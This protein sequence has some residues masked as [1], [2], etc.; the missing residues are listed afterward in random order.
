MSTAPVTEIDPGPDWF[1]PESAPPRPRWWG[2][3]AVF[4]AV[5]LAGVLILAGIGAANGKSLIP[6]LHAWDGNWYLRIAAT[7]YSALSVGLDA[8]GNAAVDT[9][10]AFFPGYPVAI[11]LLGALTHL[12]PIAAGLLIS[13]VAG[14]TA[15]YGI[16]RLCHLLNYPQWTGMIGVALFAATPM[17]VTLSM[18]YTE[19]LFTALAIWALVGI[20]RQNWLA[21]A[22][23]CGFAGLV[24][25]S[26]AVLVAV[27]G[28]ALVV[29]V[30]RGRSHPAALLYLVAGASGLAGYYAF[31]VN[32]TDNL[33]GWFV[34]QKAGWGTAF[35]FGK[36]S[37]TFAW[38]VLTSDAPLMETLNVVSMLGAVALAVIAVRERLPWPLAAH[39]IGIVVMTIGS[40][41]VTY[42]KMRLLVPAATLLIPVAA[43]LARRRPGT[44]IAVLA[45]VAV[46][47]GWIGAYALTDWRYAI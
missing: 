29:S 1:E 33:A 36:D 31:V 12:P 35:D 9:T 45:A 38:T 26:A 17:S 34:L 5:R 11:S 37:A 46:L 47:G 2:P 44:I 40:S 6:T 16:S 4:V 42:S 28:V 39:G 27:L 19:A 30:A 7:G 21:A 13:A 18:V 8:H 20:V 15:A 10:M 22:I 3:G 41:G 32:R 43:G 14:I 24:R 25:P 23:C